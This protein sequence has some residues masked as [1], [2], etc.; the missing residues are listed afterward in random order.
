MENRET[1]NGKTPFYMT[2]PMQNLYL[3]E[4]EYEKDLE[5]MI[6]LYPQEVK[7]L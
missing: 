2:Y 7:T 6:E 4:M 1:Y 3:A 5:R